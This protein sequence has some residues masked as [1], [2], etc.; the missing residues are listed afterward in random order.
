MSKHERA[1]R[2]KRLFTIV[3]R[4]DWLMVS[5]NSVQTRLV[6]NKIR[7]RLF[8]LTIIIDYV[9]WLLQPYIKKKK[10]KGRSQLLLHAD[11]S[12]TNIFLKNVNDLIF[13][14]IQVINHIFKESKSYRMCT[15]VLCQMC[16]TN[17]HR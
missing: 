4:H 17:P 6:D 2:S 3:K 14:Y 12:M 16:Q 1:R 13:Q 8:S 15:L 5:E 10:K 9:D 7:C 11:F